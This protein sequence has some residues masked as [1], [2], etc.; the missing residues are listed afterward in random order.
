MKEIKAIRRADIGEC[1]S[2]LFFSAVNLKCN[3]QRSCISFVTEYIKFE[4]IY[5]CNFMNDC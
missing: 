3:R 1:L 5:I 4:K 2:P